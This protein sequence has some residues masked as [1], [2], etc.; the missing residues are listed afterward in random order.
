MAKVPCRC[1]GELVTKATERNHLKNRG[2]TL[3]TAIQQRRL[4]AHRRVDA[5]VRREIH[6]LQRRCVGLN[7]SVQLQYC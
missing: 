6:Q 3:Q 7:I 2:I 5:N 1:C 4:A